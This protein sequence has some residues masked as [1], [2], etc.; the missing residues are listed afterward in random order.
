MYKIGLT[1]NT[2]VYTGSQYKDYIRNWAKKWTLA[3]PPPDLQWPWI[4][5]LHSRLAETRKKICEEAQSNSLLGKFE[6]VHKRLQVP[7][8]VTISG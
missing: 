3:T 4:R 7:L 8:C 1:A 2:V 5:T 6:F